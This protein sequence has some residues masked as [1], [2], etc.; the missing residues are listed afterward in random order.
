MI[1]FPDNVNNFKSECKSTT[2][3]LIGTP[4]AAFY[5]LMFNNGF[6]L[7]MS[8]V[9]YILQMRFEKSRRAKHAPASNDKEMVAVNQSGEEEIEPKKESV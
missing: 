9:I 6:N 2:N 7:L 5:W 8:A 3:F 1:K 4:I